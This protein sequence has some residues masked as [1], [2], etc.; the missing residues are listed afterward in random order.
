MLGSTG[1]ERGPHRAAGLFGRAVAD[2]FAVDAQQAGQVGEEGE[3]LAHQRA[4]DLVLA[5]HFGEQS[6]QLG[7]P[8]P[9]VLGSLWVEQ[10][11][12]CVE[13]DGV[14]CNPEAGSGRV[15]DGGAVALQLA[16]ALHLALKFRQAAEHFL[17]LPCADG[18]SLAENGI[19]EPL[20]GDNLLVEVTHD[21]GAEVGRRRGVCHRG[22]HEAV[23]PPVAPSAFTADWVVM[24][25]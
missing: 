7:A 2:V 3:L 16:A 6:A 9:R 21:L 18:R 24:A 17:D 11:S 12:E 25:L 14:G 22:A 15:K 23:T 5:L 4:V 13:G 8:R 1:V 19:E 10:C 20:G